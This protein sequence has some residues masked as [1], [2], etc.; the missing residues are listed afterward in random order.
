MAYVGAVYSIARFRR[1]ADEVL[2]ELARHQRA[3]DRPAPQHNCVLRI[4]L[5][6][7]EYSA[8]NPFQ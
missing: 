6:T 1:A 4:I 3:A 5:M 7:T 8:V 2:D